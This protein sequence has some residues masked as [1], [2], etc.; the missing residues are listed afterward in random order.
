MKRC[1]CVRCRRRHG[2][3]WE[4]RL[5]QSWFG[6]WLRLRLRWKRPPLQFTG[7]HRLALERGILTH[8]RLL[9]SPNGIII[10]YS[11]SRRNL[12]AR[13]RSNRLCTRVAHLLS[14][15]PTICFL[16][17]FQTQ[18]QT[19]RRLHPFLVFPHKPQEH[20]L[21]FVPC[22]IP[23]FQGRSLSQL[24]NSARTAAAKAFAVCWSAERSSFSPV[25]CA[26]R[27]SSSTHGEIF[28]SWRPSATPH[29]EF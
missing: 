1:F 20:P 17:R 24:G 22:A 12:K 29:I 21:F 2:R 19:P 9:P 28:P 16:V 5:F 7:R 14:Q 25:R 11:R 13:R 10:C 8:R 6:G 4:R 18:N 15:Q 23:H 3:Y 27:R 26:E